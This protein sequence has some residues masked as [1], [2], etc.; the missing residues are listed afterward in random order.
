MVGDQSYMSHQ[1]P[2]PLKV[3]RPDEVR[4]DTRR[5]LVI[6]EGARGRSGVHAV[7]SSPATATSTATI[8]GDGDA[9]LPHHL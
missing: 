7:S 9:A 6:V 8:P 2:D 4:T 5:E 1:T 3:R